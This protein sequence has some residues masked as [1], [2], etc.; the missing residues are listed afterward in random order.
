VDAAR[1]RG[2]KIALYH[3]LNH[4]TS[5]PD[6]VDALED[7][8]A[9]TAFI[10]QTHERIRE[11]VTRYNPIDVLW[12]DGWWPFNAEGWQAESMNEM[13]HSIQPQILFNGRNGL[14]GDFATPE[15]HLTAPKP[16]RPWEG[17]ITLN[18]N[19]GFHAGDH[20]WK[21]PGQVV[22]MLAEC[23]QGQGNLVLN[24]GP[25]G[26]GSIP[27]ASTRVLE[28][29]GN[30]LQRHGECIFDTDRF[31]YD[32]QERGEPGVHRGDWCNHGPLTVRGNSLY[33]LARNWP[34]STLSLGGLQCRVQRVSLLGSG[35]EY[36]YKQEGERLIISGLPAESP[37]VVCPVLRFDCDRPPSLYLC[38][39]MRTPRVPHPRYD[40]CPS[41]I[42]H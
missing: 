3:S 36:S 39:G 10:A 40:P 7:K 17:C 2:L 5:Q 33:L 12:Y 35:Q 23:A 30:W 38:G 19:W 14:A 27:E 28:T 32:L 25:R 9:Y 11:L 31:T 6:A 26:D 20:D 8:A 22:D 42:A 37:D 29:V 24:I 4:W 16:W 21:T 13:V 15:N 1:K 18:R 34:G 41:D